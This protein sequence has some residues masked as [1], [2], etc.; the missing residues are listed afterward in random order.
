MIPLCLLLYVIK[1]HYVC[2]NLIMD[3]MGM[4]SKKVNEKNVIS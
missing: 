1:S 3:E 4:A 2:G